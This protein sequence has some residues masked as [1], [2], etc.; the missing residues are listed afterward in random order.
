MNS[1]IGYYTT[2]FGE[3]WEK[4]LYD[5]VL[6]S[7]QGAL[8]QVKLNVPQIDAIFYA[9]MMSG[10][11]GNNLHANAKIAELLKTNIPIFRVEAA[12]ASGGM[13]FQLANT[14]LAA[15][16]NKTVLVVGA[17]KMTD[18]SPE[19][20]TTALSSAASGEEQEAG[21]TFP[22]LYAMLANVYMSTYKATEEDLAHVP[23]KNHLH[24]TLNNKAHFQKKI[25]VEQVMKSAYIA[26][27][28]KVL[29]CS[30]ISDGA[31][32]VVLTNNTPHTKTNKKATVHACEIATDSISLKGRTHLDRLMA[33]QIAADKAFKTAGIKR[34]DISI[35]ELHDCFS[36]AEILAM[37]DIGFWKK[38]TGGKEILTGSTTYGSGGNLIVNTSG[39]LK[40]AGHPVGATGIKQIGEIYLQLTGQAEKR[41]VTNPSYG[42]A[43][44]VG[45]SGGTAVVSILGI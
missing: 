2:Q 6:E 36:I 15:N 18:Y 11:L 14:Y 12:C 39:G 41:Q 35:A 38:G 5:L 17:E 4:S 9:N 19:Q 23:V 25:N 43:H 1:V 8:N 44:N 24:G 45:G 28:L 40:A 34:A 10:V 27:P 30:P 32:T 37:E 3:I 16:K 7:I 29:D 20:T 42:L 22:G 31:A 13:A 26:H 33:T 21:I